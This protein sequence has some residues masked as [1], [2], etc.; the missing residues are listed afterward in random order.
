MAELKTPSV[1]DAFTPLWSGQALRLGRE[2]PA[3]EMTRR[4]AEETL[5]RLGAG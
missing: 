4:L 1:S 3:G 5:F 2:L